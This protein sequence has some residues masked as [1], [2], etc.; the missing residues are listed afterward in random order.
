MIRSIAFAAAFVL[1]LPAMAGEEDIK[2]KSGD[3]VEVVDDNCAACHSLDY[4]QMNS[5]I[6][7]QK[8]WQKVVNKMVKIFGAPIAEDDQTKIVAYLTATYGKK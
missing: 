6:L 7:D 5:P 2:L 1:S 8:G 4:I 3:G